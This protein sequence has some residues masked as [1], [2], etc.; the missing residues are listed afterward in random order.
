MKIPDIFKEK[1]NC[2][3]CKKTIL[4]E[5]AKKEQQD[6]SPIYNAICYMDSYKY[7]CDDCHDNRTTSCNVCFCLI[8]TKDAYR[9][10]DSTSFYFRVGNIYYC[11]KC[12]PNYTE[13]RNKGSL[14][15]VFYKQIEVDEK[16]EPIGYIKI[17]DDKKSK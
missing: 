10:K 11:T 14:G 13:I 15:T 16:G 1:V 5:N 8:K 17:N 12:K 4:K 2:V 9:V 6:S 3:D 7:Y